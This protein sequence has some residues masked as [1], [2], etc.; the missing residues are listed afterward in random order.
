MLQLAIRAGLPLIHARTTDTVNFPALLAHLA[1][2]PVFEIKTSACQACQG[3]GSPMNELRA[4][5]SEGAVLWTQNPINQGSIMYDALASDGCTLVALN[6]N[7]LPAECFDAGQVPVSIAFIRSQLR[8]I[9]PDGK[10]DEI[11]PGLGGLTYKEVGD[12]IRLAEAGTG[13]LTLRAVLGARRSAFSQLRGLDIISTEMSFYAPEADVEEYISWAKD[14]LLGDFDHRLRPRGILLD[15]V[16]GTGKTMAAKRI[17]SE[18]GVQLLRLDLGAIKGKWVGESEGALSDALAQVDREAPCVLLLDEVE[19]LFA[20]RVDDPVASNLLASL[21][22]WLAEHRSQV[23]VAMTTND[24]AALPSELWRDGRI[25]CCLELSGLRNEQHVLPFA[26]ELAATFGM[27]KVVGFRSDVLEGLTYPV[28]Q[29][30]VEEKVKKVVR[31][32]LTSKTS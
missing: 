4:K 25:D 5:A 32:W 23:L 30:S 9:L 28:P 7:P 31:Q 6:Q 18:I 14:F 13:E 11:L 10:V 8:E 24:K 22:W 26:M 17:A 21:L 19:K 20:Q 1:G 15:G 3:P 27:P 2:R 16:P 29:A 12:L